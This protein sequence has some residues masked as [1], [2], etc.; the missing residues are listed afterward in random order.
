MR[1]G[2]ILRIIGGL[3]SAVAEVTSERMPAKL[4][5]IGVR[6][7]FGKSGTNEEM[8]KKFGLRSEDIAEEV[9]SFLES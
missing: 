3:G 2:L 9:V 4:K 5:R 8:K 7:V 6:D 1:R